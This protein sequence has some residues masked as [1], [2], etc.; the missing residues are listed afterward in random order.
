MRISGWFIRLGGAMA[1]LVASAQARAQ[2]QAAVITGKVTGEADRPLGGANV[3]IAELNVGA[4]TRVDG[5]YSL[6]VAAGR[7][8]GQ[9]VVLRVRFLGH[10]PLT[11]QVVLA[12]G[13]Q[14]QDFRLVPDPVKLSEVVVTG[15]ADAIEK[16]KLAFSVGT[17][18]SDQL[19]DVPA[20]SAIGGI[21]GKVAG[22]RVLQSG[23]DP[24]AAPVI[25][26][27]S[28]TS[29]TGLQDPL[30]IIDG[31]ITRA[32]LA[33][34]NSEDIE[35]IEVIKGAAASSLYGSDAANGVVQLFT[36][37]GANQ[38][39]GQQVVTFR[40]EA[41][42]N[43]QTK[44]QPQSGA[45]AWQ[46]D[47]SGNYIR[48]NCGAANPATCPRQAK[49]NGIADNAYLNPHD[50]LKEVI[51]PGQFWTSYLSIGQKVGATNYNA[52]FQH[53]RNEGI[54]KELKG[55]TRE[56]V[57]INVDRGVNDKL[58]ASFGTFFGKSNNQN[59]IDGPNGPFFAVTFVEPDVDIFAKNP[60][61]SPYAAKIPDRISNA[62]NPLYFLHNQK[63]TTD[64]TRFTGTGKLRYRLADWLTAEGNYNYDQENQGIKQLTPR[65]F[66]DANGIAGTGALSQQEV[67]GRTVNTGATLMSIRSFRDWF[68]N[69]TKAAYIFESQF[70]NQVTTTTGSLTVPGTPEFSAGE[71]SQLTAGSQT[72]TVRNRNTFLISTFD[73]R[74]KFIIDGLVRRDESSLFGKDNRSANY[75]RASAAYRVSQDFTLP[76][77]DEL[78]LR[79]SRGTAGLRPVFDAQYESFAILGGS[80]TKV[81]LGNRDLKP[82]HS[83]ETE[84]GFNLDFLKRYSLEYTYSQKATTDQIIQVPLSAAT[85]YQTQ[86]QN[87]GALEG[88]THEIALGALIATSPTFSWRANVTGDRTRQ[89]ITA[90]S[91]APFL[92]GPTFP[93]ATAQ[94]QMFRMAAGQPFGVMY[95]DK[96][97][98]NIDQLYDD[99]AKKA[100]SGA[101]QAWSR[102]SVLVNEEGFVVRKSSWRTVS[103]SAIKYVN[104]EGKT[105]V[106][107]G[108]VNPDF[109]L[110]LNNNMQFHGLALNT[111]FDWSKGGNI[112]NATRQWPFFENRDWVYDQRAKPVAERKSQ[113]YYNVFYNGLD[114][115]DYFVEKGTYV[116]LKEL[117][118]NYTVPASLVQRLKFGGVS[119]ARIG[120]VGRNIM[121]WT[122]YSGYDPEVSGLGGDPH[123]FRFDGFNYPNFRTFTAVI[124]L[125][126]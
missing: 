90:L 110:S 63:N 30:I 114:A 17:V 65:G 111:V 35:R 24:G 112:Y 106:Q 126:F 73:I 1:V 20:T 22:A 2:G 45:H 41:G 67:N 91:V 75:Y 122:K 36:K 46:V 19:K 76:G 109:N 6:T 92:T 15:T 21:T 11:R 107:I 80:P 57:R 87:A 33:D 113:Q 103:E 14:V 74:D 34:I 62:T 49:S 88:K 71:Q 56:N 94:V 37:R 84:A 26:L 101:G 29:L 86:W 104:S 50:H 97:V 116:K 68:T 77:V 96:W 89:R 66:L 43:F 47:A 3:Y 105:K 7:A 8:N 9:G 31:T 125:G 85:G 44:F 53:N 115:N 83:T 121:T 117:S 52:S 54:I 118:V 32:S 100:A 16:K 28:S 123:T 60:D 10:T 61:G 42:A 69:T 124:E 99:P 95:G 81:N 25:R 98:R 48:T 120:I 119:S 38:A 102:D 51:Q 5:T 4:N 108:D 79:A 23:G 64:R 13:S 70:N 82:A 93:G 39:E 12:G 18:S 40:S 72:I 27:R 58:D 55:F 78:R 59:T